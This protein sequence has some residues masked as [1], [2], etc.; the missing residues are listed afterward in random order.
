LHV[1][2]SVAG[3]TALYLHGH[4][5]VH[6]LYGCLRVGADSLRSCVSAS[7]RR[8]VVYWL[9]ALKRAASRA[10]DRTLRASRCLDE[11]LP[12]VFMR[13]LYAVLLE[14]TCIDRR[15]FITHVEAA[16]LLTSEAFG[17]QEARPRMLCVDKTVVI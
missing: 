9:V 1:A 13:W 2:C 12:G 11:A 14:Y 5:Y 8:H 3:A 10:F 6:S 15:G 4:A 17:Q 16:I 7:R